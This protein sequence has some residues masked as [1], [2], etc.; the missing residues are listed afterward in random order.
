MNRTSKLLNKTTNWISLFMV[1]GTWG[2][3][4]THRVKLNLCWFWLDSLFA[5]ASDNI[6]VTFISLYI[7]SLGAT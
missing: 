4:L 6:S 5:S 3:S 2:D 1:G 7:L